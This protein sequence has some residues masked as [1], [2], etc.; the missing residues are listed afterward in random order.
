MHEVAISDNTHTRRAAY[1][2][3][4]ESTLMLPIIG[5]AE[6]S[7]WEWKKAQAGQAF[8]FVTNRNAEGG[9]VFLAFT[10]A[11]SVRAW[12]PVGCSCVAFNAHDLFSTLL[13]NNAAAVVVNPAG[14]TGGKITQEELEALAAGT[15]PEYQGNA[16]KMQTASGTAIYVGMPAKQ[17]PEHLMTRLRDGMAAHSEICAGYLFQSYVQGRAKASLTAGL[18]FSKPITQQKTEE[19]MDDLAGRVRWLMAADESLDVMALSDENILRLVQQA[20]APLFERA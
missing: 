13:Q 9:T 1:E 3:L 20:T 14:P 15:I 2:A 6:T 8:Q 19:L 11:P 4:L 17:P 18:L 10:D 7:K 5:Y 12:R 16:A